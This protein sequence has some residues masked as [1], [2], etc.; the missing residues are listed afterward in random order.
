MKLWP[1]WAERMAEDPPPGVSPRLHRMFSRWMGFFT[2]YL[3]VTTAGF[4]LI[5]IAFLFLVLA[6]AR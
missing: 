6:G 2:V 4:V 3:I 5:G 1:D